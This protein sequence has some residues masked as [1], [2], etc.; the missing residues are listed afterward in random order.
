MKNLVKSFWQAMGVRLPPACWGF[1]PSP[2][3]VLC[4]FVKPP[5]GVCY[6]GFLTAGFVV[7]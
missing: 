5:V 2:S 7:K 1:F 4:A 3:N 6:C